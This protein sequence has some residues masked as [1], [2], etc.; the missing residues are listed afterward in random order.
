MVT[1]SRNL[2]F[3]CGGECYSIQQ[4]R[5]FR[6]KVE[7]DDI[8]SKFST[9]FALLEVN[10]IGKT[11]PQCRGHAAMILIDGSWHLCFLWR[12]VFEESLEVYLWTGTL[13]SGFP[14]VLVDKES[15]LRSLEFR[16]IPQQD[17]CLVFVN[18][19]ARLQLLNHSSLHRK[20]MKWSINMMEKFNQVFMAHALFIFQI[21]GNQQYERN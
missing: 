21:Q 20:G 17:L 1:S 18:I 8:K 13:Q 12:L 4:G 2:F 5:H 10:N 15:R 9:E 19:I 11:N 3:S 6:R 14:D 16:T 7:L